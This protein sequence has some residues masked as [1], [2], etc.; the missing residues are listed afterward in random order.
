MDLVRRAVGPGPAVHTLWG[1][2]TP[3]R[4]EWLGFE[5]VG[6][7]LSTDGTFLAR[8][9]RADTAPLPQVVSGRWTRGNGVV[10]TALVLPAR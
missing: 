3:S 8:I 5:E 7:E 1:A 9:R 10:V 2:A 6:I 4:H